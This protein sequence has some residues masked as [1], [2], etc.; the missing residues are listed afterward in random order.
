MRDKT[1]QILIMK[2][3]GLQ[4]KQ[5]A[6]KLGLHRRSVEEHLLNARKEMRAKTLYQAIARAVRD[7]IIGAGE[8]SVIFILTWSCLFGGV[9]GRRGPQPRTTSRLVRREQ[10]I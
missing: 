7:G 1:R 8:I 6:D 10:I 3:N 4:S 5:I 2:A 9:E